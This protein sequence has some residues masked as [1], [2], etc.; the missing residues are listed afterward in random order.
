MELEGRVALVTGASRGIGREVALNLARR[1][2]D[3]ALN[4][5]QSDDAA[6]AIES[7]IVKLGRGATRVK[8]SV[9]DQAAAER[10][11]MTVSET[12]G[13][14]DILVNNA[15]IVR[16]KFLVNMEPEDWIDVIQT[17]LVGVFNVTKLIAFSMMRRRRGRII[18][19]SSL[20]ALMGA[21]GQTNY[22]A[23]KGGVIGFTKSLS[24]ELAPFGITVN[25]VA[26]GYV[27]TDMLETMSEEAMSYYLKLIPLGRIGT[28]E[29]VAELVA[30]LASD[31]A[32]YITG[33][34]IKVDGGLS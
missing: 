12:L 32:S 13:P 25:A 4:Y 9:A 11:A 10:M 20:S 17:N 8:C 1:G 6:G 24:R 5:Q 33:Q 16:D 31:R 23:S 21:A 22:A 2:A 27:E 3:V 18:N 14:V 28:P 7:E 34:V 26:P 15:G 30:F 29:D 19:I